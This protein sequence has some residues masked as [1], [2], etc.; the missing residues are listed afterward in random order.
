[1]LFVNGWKTY[2]LPLHMNEHRLKRIIEKN[3]ITHL[4]FY[5]PTEFD[6]KVT[7]SMLKELLDVFPRLSVI[8]YGAC[9]HLISKK[10]HIHATSLRQ[11]FEKIKKIEEKTSSSPAQ[12]PSTP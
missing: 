5:I 8:V 10:A 7:D 9:S 2:Y 6:A 12:A 3:N 11:L 1:M 4:A